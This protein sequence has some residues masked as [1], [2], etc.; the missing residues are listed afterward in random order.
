MV[1]PSKVHDVVMTEDNLCVKDSKISSISTDIDNE[2]ASKM[3]SAPQNSQATSQNVP[4]LP[5]TQGSCAN[6]SI[7]A[8]NGP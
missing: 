6:V 3:I 4:P 5:L 1:T 2:E 8:T 7:T